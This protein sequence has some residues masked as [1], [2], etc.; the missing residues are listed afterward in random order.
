MLLCWLAGCGRVSFDPL[1]GDGGTGAG[2]SNGDS[3]DVPA[4]PPRVFLIE[5]DGVSR[6]SYVFTVDVTN[7]RLTELGSI[8]ASFGE[9]DGLAYKDPNHLYMTSYDGKLVEITLSPMTATTLMTGL[10]ALSSLDNDGAN[11]IAVDD[12]TDTL[13]HL[14]PEPTQ[15]LD[16]MSLMYMG[17]AVIVD[18]GD[19]TR[20]DADSW[21]LWTNVGVLYR[22]E[23]ATATALLVGSDP[24][25]PYIVGITKV[26]ST[27]YGISTDTDSIY[28]I[29]PS[30][31]T[32]GPPETICLACP[33]TYDMAF[34]DLAI[35]P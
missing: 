27:L 23:D 3:V 15:V 32:L 7:G 24:G 5:G 8:A 26:G 29:D 19:I 13:V 14:M 10:G 22:V 18:G 20:N 12:N 17:S 30:D 34:G 16:A 1:G 2:D 33:T 9:P 28:A 6:P 11:L 25:L 31:G 35:G 21:W 4:G